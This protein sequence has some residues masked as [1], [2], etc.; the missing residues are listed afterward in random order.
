MRRV[1]AEGLHNYQ[2]DALGYQLSIVG[3]AGRRLDC[4]QRT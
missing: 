1:H 3:I 2:S 4:A